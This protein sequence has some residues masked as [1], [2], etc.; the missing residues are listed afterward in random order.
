MQIT[1]SRL[2]AFTLLEIMIVVAIIGLLAG[3]STPSVL[4]ARDTSQLNAIVSNLR[5]IESTKDQWAIEQKQGDGAQPLD[6]DLAPYLRNYTMPK[7]ILGET[8]N[9]NPIGTPATA[10][11]PNTVRL[12]TYPPGGTVNLP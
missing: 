12:G 8:Y 10:T 9:I 7:L 3:I 2:A 1:R 4:K 6:T 5:I 11:I